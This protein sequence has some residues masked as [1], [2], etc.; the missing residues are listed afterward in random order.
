MQVAITNVI[1]IT[2]SSYYSLALKADGSVWAWGANPYGAFGRGEMTPGQNTYPPIQSSV[3]NVVAAS[4]GDYFS[5]MIDGIGGIWGAGWNM[6]GQLGDG[7]NLSRATPARI[8]GSLDYI[9][10]AAQYWHSVAVKEAQPYIS[11]TTSVNSVSVPEGGTNTFH[12]KLSAQPWT[13]VTIRVTRESGDS[14]LSAT[15]GTNLVFDSSNWDIWQT[16]TLAAA[17]DADASNGMAVIWVSGA[18]VGARVTAIEAEND[19]TL[20]VYAGTGGSVTPNGATVV[21]K[22][23]TTG[24]AASPGPAYLFA[25]WSVLSG[26]PTIGDTNVAG[27]T[28][29]ITGDATIQAN[30]AP[31]PIAAPTGLTATAIATNR[32]D[33]SWTDNATNETGYVAQHSTD[34]N[35]WV[36]ITLTAS[37]VTSLSDTGLTADTL[38]YYR[39]AASNAAGLSA[40][41]YASATTLTA[42]TGSSTGWSESFEGYTAGSQLHGQGGWKGWD[43]TSAYGAMVTGTP[44]HAGAKSVAIAGDSDLVHEFSGCTNGA[45]TFTAWQYVPEAFSGKQYIS[46]L[47]QYVDGGS[48]KWAVQVA[49]DAA[50]GKVHSDFDSNEVALV[51]GRWVQLHVEVDLAA[52]RQRFFYDGQQVYQ[53]SWTNGVD[54]GGQRAIAALNLFANGASAVYYDDLSLWTAYE[55]WRRLYF[56]AGELDDAGVS[57]DNADPDGDNFLNWHEWNAGTDPRGAQ[58]RLALYATTN[59]VDTDGIFVVRWQSVEGKRYTL[60]ATTNL[61]TDFTNVLTNIQAT[62]V[63]NV[64][65]DNAAGAGMKF[66]RVRLE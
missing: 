38:Y 28:A 40:Y 20:T 42:N 16:V 30:F 43:N 41:A 56:T 58:S 48:K 61:M 33:L 25:N 7:T 31:A 45:W 2:A 53:K 47:N 22:G 17:E 37:N 18:D 46:L 8:A 66:Y 27:T 29:A 39:V 35:A 44:T 13:N 11:V 4:A 52:D 59:N 51:K 23:A 55:A 21:T 14:D 64:H 10:V 6:Y 3:S 19:A 12:V 62:P 54:L 9:A 57:G 65:T 1:A 49:F 63:M 5:L 50:A 34:S 32:V 26:S 60:Q 15:A 24:I 36:F